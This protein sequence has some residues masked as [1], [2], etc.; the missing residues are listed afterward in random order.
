MMGGKRPSSRSGIQSAGEPYQ[1]D[2]LLDSYLKEK[3][4]NPGEFPDLFSQNFVASF[5]SRWVF[6]TSALGHPIKQIS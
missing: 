1:E 5:G 2:K 3:V 4:Q 6:S